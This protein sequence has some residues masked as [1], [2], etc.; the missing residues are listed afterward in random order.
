MI[1][2]KGSCLLLQGTAFYHFSLNLQ[3]EVVVSCS[4]QFFWLFLNYFILILIVSWLFPVLY[5]FFSSIKGGEGGAG[6]SEEG[7]G[8][9]KGRDRNPIKIFTVFQSYSDQVKIKREGDRGEGGHLIKT[10]IRLRNCLGWIMIKNSFPCKKYPAWVTCQVSVI[11][12]GIVHKTRYPKN[13][14]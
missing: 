2:A 13:V 10:F 3:P 4:F 8:R 5:R 7:E 1:L 11:S 6:R 14:F 9:E 12:R